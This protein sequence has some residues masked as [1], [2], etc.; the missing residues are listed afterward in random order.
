M[1]QCSSLLNLSTTWDI[2]GPFQIGTREAEWGADPLEKYGG[3]R[4]LTYDTTS[5][6][7]SSLPINGVAQWSQTQLSAQNT[8]YTRGTV[9]VGF[10]NVDWDNL[11]SIYGW[12]GIQFQAWARG[13]L[14]V[15]ADVHAQS[16]QTTIILH[17]W[18]V[19]EFWVDDT[20]YFGGDFYGYRRAPVVL[21]LAPGKHKFDVRVTHDIRNFGGGMPPR[22]AFEV[23]A[24]VSPGGL[25]VVPEGAVMSDLVEGRIVGKWVSVPLRNDAVNW[26]EVLEVVSVDNTTQLSFA[27]DYL[28]LGFAPGQTRPVKFRVEQLGSNATDIALKFR[29]R[30][31][32]ES[33]S[34]WVPFTRKL[35]KISHWY[36]PQKYT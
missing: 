24:K 10:E 23:E 33:G 8:N 3:F 25:I 16:D 2:L 31:K 11:R 27:Q 9:T 21:R 4:N 34:Q 6:F 7:K 1:T 35:N 13:S 20:Q 17:V 15:C 19:G 32:G 30:A 22:I 28:P 14:D 5:R 12:S 26:I 29:Y 36:L 18:N